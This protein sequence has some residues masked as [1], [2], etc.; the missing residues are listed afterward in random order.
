MPYDLNEL[1]PLDTSLTG[2]IIVYADAYSDDASLLKS[3]PY[4]LFNKLA[5]ELSAFTQISW[6]V[7][8]LLLSQRIFLFLEYIILETIDFSMSLYLVLCLLLLMTGAY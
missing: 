4:S 1:H 8:V 3:I 7:I 6:F 5:C 2:L